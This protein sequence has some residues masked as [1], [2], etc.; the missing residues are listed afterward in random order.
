MTYSPN[1]DDRLWKEP[2]REG[3]FRFTTPLRY[4]V[5][6]LLLVGAVIVIWYLVS[7]VR[8]SYDK[9]NLALIRADENPY[10][11]KAKDQDLPNIKHQDKLVYGRIRN[12][13]NSPTVE[14]ILP[15][16]E[17]PIVHTAEES[18]N[19]KMVDQYI[20]QDV[21]TAKIVEAAAISPEETPPALVSIEDLIEEEPSERPSQEKKVAKGNIFI[22]LGSLKSHDLAELEWSR[23]SQKHKDLLGGLT[24]AIQKV[25][26]GADQGIYYRLRTGP[27]ENEEEAKKVCASLK[28]RKVDCLVIH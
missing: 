24:P 15:D 27:L 23:V 28:E 8:R 14:H 22:Q 2:R 9:A 13:Q 3:W 10:K 11:V 7:P 21:E 18:S 16:P 25:D 26:L 5:F 6:L 17:P 19:L 12:D 20:P 4:V 1:D